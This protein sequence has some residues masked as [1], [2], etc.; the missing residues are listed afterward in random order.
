MVLRGLPLYNGKGRIIDRT[1][2]RRLA[3]PENVLEVTTAD[4]FSMRVMPNDLIGRHIFLTGRFDRCVVEAL[5]SHARQGAVLW[6]IGANVGYVSCAFLRRVPGSR[7]VAVEPLRDVAELLRENV[8]HVGGDRATV[9][10]A[11]VSDH[12]GEAAFVRTPGNLGK[13]HVAVGGEGDRVRLVTPS[14][15]LGMSGGRVDLVKIDVEGHELAVLNGLA[16]VL[17]SARPAAV[18]FEHHTSGTV[19]PAIER[20]FSDSG[21]E[22]LCIYRRW[23]GWKLAPANVSVPGFSPSSDF[24]SVPRS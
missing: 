24:V 7:V 22:I 19:D 9:V 14:E 6:D 17:R 4:G 3:F 12:P 16:P 13:S 23:N 1:R 11:A 20:I 15:L 8:R 10:S 5:V 18:V 21:Y 2:L